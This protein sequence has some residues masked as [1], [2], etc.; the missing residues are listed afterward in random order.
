MKDYATQDIRNVALVGHGGTGKTTLT[1][2]ALFLTGAINRLGRVDDGTTT[3]DYDADEIKRKISVN[4]SLLPTEWKGRKINL[5]DTPGYADFVGEVKAG[6]RAADAALIVVCAASGLQVGTENVWGFIRERNLPAAAVINRLDRE[7]ADFLLTLGQ[8]QGFF[9]KRCVPVHLA[10]GAQ[11]TFQGVVDLLSLKA[12]TGDK[13]VEG[14]LPGSL[15]DLVGRYREQLTEAIAETDDALINK[16]LE[17]EELTAEEMQRGLRAALISGSVV[18]VFAASGLKSVG[19]GPL[20]DALS[21][22]LPSPVDSGEVPAKD[23]SGAEQR[24]APTA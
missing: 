10:I 11:D 22:Y 5:I 3:S 12:Y 1:E 24:L 20:L 8:L 2:A 17:G 7:N 18:P 16:Y 4:L 21:D 6:L 13:A 19:V 15:G 23:A 9:G 14:E